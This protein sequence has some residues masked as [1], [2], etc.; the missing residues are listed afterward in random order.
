MIK[1]RTRLR[2]ISNA[3]ASKTALIDVPCG[4]R[5]HT[6]NLVYTSTTA[7]TLATLAAEIAEIRIK[8]NGRIQRTISGASLKVIYD[9][10]GPSSSQV[11]GNPT[12]LYSIQPFGVVGTTKKVNIPLHF[13]EPWRNSPQDKDALAWATAGWQSFQ[14]EIDFGANFSAF[15]AN[16]VIDML[17]PKGT[18]GI[19]KW[20]RQNFPAG[21]GLSM[22]W[23]TLERRDWLQQISIKDPST[24]GT[25]DRVTLKQ[26][27]VVLHDLDSGSNIALLSNNEMSPQASGWY[28]LVL[29]HDDNLGSAVLT[30]GSRDLLLT[31]ENT[32]ATNMV[33]SCEVIIQRLGTPE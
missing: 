18:P 22:D 11:L 6:V 5:Y 10:L 4:P 13:A 28:H 12:G 23:S 31:I 30:D 19:V 2:S 29:D 24:S 17:Q 16:A 33:G 26:N 8:A 1:Q 14:I 3:A 32:Q 20:I 25:V 27:G 15:E 9:M 7:T 21:G